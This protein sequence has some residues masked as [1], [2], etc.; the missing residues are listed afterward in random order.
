M[1]ESLQEIVE[2]AERTQK[3][4]AELVIDAEKLTSGLPTEDIRAR[5]LKR[6]QTMQHSAQEGLD[7]PIKSISGIS[8][9][10]AHKF[11]NWLDENENVP[12]TGSIL[13]RAIARALA[14]NEVNAGMGCIVATPTAGSAGILPAALITLQEEYRFSDDQIVDALFVAS[15]IGM[16]VVNR[17][18]VSGAM[19]GCQAETGSA[20]AMAAGASV[21]LLGG[22]PCQSMQA[23]G[24]TLKNMLGLVCDPVAG[25]VEVP[26]VKRNAAGV[27]QCFVAIDLAL[28]GVESI[29]PADEVIDAMAHIG[30]V[31]HKD[32][33]ETGLGGLAATPTGRRLAKQVWEGDV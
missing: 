4:L 6:L 30:K 10:S 13:S 32:L 18:N 15:G 24:I 11:W 3:S 29:I 14:V 25:L 16:V 20:A 17:A 26:C 31:M 28:A 5:M 8:G 1:F 23:V 2:N 7:R 22:S 33:K 27:A 12:V 21:A 9:G 19:G